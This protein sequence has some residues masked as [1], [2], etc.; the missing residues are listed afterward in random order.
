MLTTRYGFA[1]TPHLGNPSLAW[2]VL[3]SASSVGATTLSLNDVSTFPSATE[4]DIEV[5]ERQTDGTVTNIEIAHVLSV[6]GMTFTLES[7]LSFA[8]SIGESVYHTLT[9]RGLKENPSNLTTAG[10]ISFLNTSGRM[11]RL[12]QPGN[13]DYVVTW[14][15]GV[16]SW[17]T[18]PSFGSIV[19]ASDFHWNGGKVRNTLLAGPVSGS[20]AVPVFR[21]LV[22]ADIPDLTSLYVTPAVLAAYA[23]PLIRTINGHSLASNVTISASDLGTGTLPL[24]RL[25]G[26]TTTQFASA[27]VSQW[28]NDA[29]Y[30]AGSLG[31]TQVAF[32]SSG[33]AGSANLTWVPPIL[34]VGGSTS[35]RFDLK[36]TNHTVDTTLTNITGV[37]STTGGTAYKFD[38][39]VNATVFAYPND[40]GDTQV[41]FNS[42]GALSG[43][44]ALLWDGSSF[45]TTAINITGTAGGGFVQ[46]VSQVSAPAAP[47]SGQTLYGTSG[48]LAWIGV[49][50]FTRTLS[51]GGLSANRVWSF[52]DVTGGIVI[53]TTS[54][55][56]TFALFASSTAGAP[57]YRAVVAADVSDLG[58]ATVAF[59]N[60][61]GNISQWTNDSSYLTSVT[62]ITGNAGT[63][64]ALQNARTINGVSFDGTANITVTAAAGTLTGGTL[65]SGVTASSLTSVGTIATGV[66][67]GTA[68]AANKGGTG[69][70]V[71]VVGDVL[72]ASTTSALSTLAAVATGNVLIS[73]GVGVISSWGKV[74][75]TTHITGVLPVAN[76][77][78]NASSAGITAFN[79]ITG[80]T[81]AGATGTTSTSLVFSTSP[82]LVTPALGTPSALVLTNATGLPEGGLSL[83]DITTANVSA[84]AHGFAPKFP[85][86]TTTFLRGDGTYATPATSSGVT[87]IATTSPISGGTITTTGTI[88][89][90]VN[91]DHAFTAAQSIAN[92]GIAVTSTD[93]LTLQNTTAATSGATVQQSPRLRFRSQVWNTTS[94]AATNTNDFFIE[95]VPVSAATPSGVLKFG[96]SLNGA[97]A[98]YPMTLTSGGALV[99]TTLNGNTFTAGTYTLTGVSGKTLTF[100]NSLTLSG[101]DGQTMTFPSTSATIARTDAANTFTGHQT[102]EGVTSTG[103]T[104]TGKFVFDTSAT[105]ITP[106]LGVATATRLGVGTAADGTYPLKVDKGSGS[107]VVQQWTNAG[108]ASGYLVIGGTG[109]IYFAADTAVVNGFGI[110][111]TAN[112]T[113]VYAGNSLSF[114]VNTGAIDAARLWLGADPTIQSVALNGP[115]T[116]VLQLGNDINGAA[117]SQTIQA[118]NGI[119]GTDKTGGNLTQRPGAGTG[120][121]AVSSYIIQ[122][123]TLGTAGTTPQTQATRI[124]VNQTTF[125][126]AEALDEVFGTTTGTKH[127][128]SATQKQAWWNATP[129]VQPSRVGQL[130]DSTTGTPSTTLVDVGVA[131]SQANVNNNFSSV[132]TKLNA[133]DVLLHT[134]GLSA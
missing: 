80:Y 26:I 8:H 95:S 59:T 2:A 76:G 86:N 74:G 120:A 22:S 81:A 24:A 41:I 78:T 112:Q 123:P 57:A 101:T 27:A 65:N 11:D 116:A 93:G 46:L 3:A 19:T 68:I 62:N 128:T 105:L 30:V 53:A 100:N 23:A 75:L 71:Y 4:F 35:A 98:T 31:D 63:A 82:V 45:H 85:N 134:L 7:A 16:P 47:A 49:N 104:G 115:A 90:L 51:A 20:D 125:T 79:N 48:G 97:S 133:I 64:T 18:G 70:T 44:S 77:G 50:G 131:F 29:N 34:T 129:V 54:T 122:T 110:N 6:S 1:D 58:S 113:D 52:P 36:S 25:V 111:G 5:G 17:N 72:Q 109:T 132:L 119:T 127:G 99:V 61:S 69:Q 89:L 84:T 60:K 87:S 56:N 118:A 126:F 117:I 14:T 88:S 106:T 124:T 9:T 33:I 10:D 92:S 37:V 108:T 103:A 42:G 107:G 21:S 121:G 13:G 15:D 73:G 12:A 94:V 43:S 55:T 130:T 114:R 91:V 102:I 83:T 39:A 96:S 67:S 28:T 40:G 66:W 32:G 38:A